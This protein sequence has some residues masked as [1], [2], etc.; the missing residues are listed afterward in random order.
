MVVS[1]R[2]TFSAVQIAEIDVQNAVVRDVTVPLLI[3]L[4][5]DVDDRRCGSQ[6]GKAQAAQLLHAHARGK[7]EI[8]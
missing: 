8:R 7:T 3:A 5:Y 2:I 6:I 4:A 1:R